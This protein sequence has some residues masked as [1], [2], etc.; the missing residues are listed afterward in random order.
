M[1]DDEDTEGVGGRGA[2]NNGGGKE[3][4]VVASDVG[5]R[6][7]GKGGTPTPPGIGGGVGLG[8]SSDAVLDDIGLKL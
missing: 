4:L 7:S 5:P 2:A 6:G 8:V 3:E 1:A